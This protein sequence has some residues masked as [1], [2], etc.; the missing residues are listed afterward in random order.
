MINENYLTGKYNI[1]K[2]AKLKQFDEINVDEFFTKSSDTLTRHLEQALDS[3]EKNSL[4]TYSMVK[5]VSVII[6]SIKYN[7]GLNASVDR[8]THIDDYDNEHVNY[9]SK[10]SVVIEK[11]PA[12]DDEVDEIR[13]VERQT[14]LD[15]GFVDYQS[16]IRYGK[17]YEFKQIVSSQLLKDFNIEYYYDKYDIRFHSDHIRLEIDRFNSLERN[18]E[19]KKLNESIKFRLN[20]NTEKRAKKAQE[21]NRVNIEF[22]GFNQ[23]STPI[24][25]KDN[26]ILEHKELIETFIKKGSDDIKTAL[27]YTK[28]K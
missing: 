1:K 23:E 6:T 5:W 16:L 19:Q 14:I 8:Y 12:T 2:V 4:I 7:E 24:K 22:G 15:L 10:N 27:R 3:L 26:Y 17:W 28:L 9:E 21:E 20:E 13:R 11:R 25:A 18:K